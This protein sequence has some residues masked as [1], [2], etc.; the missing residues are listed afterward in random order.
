MRKLIKN[1]PVSCTYNCGYIDSYENINKHYFSCKLRDFTCNIHNCSSVFKKSDFLEHITSEHPEV[2][3]NISESF[4]KIFTSKIQKKL[5]DSDF[6]STLKDKN[7]II[8]YNGY[9]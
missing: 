6:K 4:D 7:E 2:M 8:I 1:F 5:K 3:I 9:I